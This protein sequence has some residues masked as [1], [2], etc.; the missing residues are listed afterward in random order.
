MNIE[1]IRQSADENT[2]PEILTQL[3]KS[4]DHQTRKYVAKNPNTPVE[5]LFELGCEFPGE[6]LNNPI[7]LLL[8]LE[9]PNFIT[10]IPLKTLRSLAYHSEATLNLITEY[11][12]Q[13]SSAGLSKSELEFLLK[14]I[15][16]NDISEKALK[17]LTKC[18]NEELAE[19]ARLHVNYS[20]KLPNSA[21]IAEN[22]LVKTIKQIDNSLLQEQ[23]EALARIKLIPK[24]FITHWNE[25]PRTARLLYYIQKIYSTQTESEEKKKPIDDLDL[26]K[27]SKTTI[28][29]FQKLA[30]K[31]DH[32]L[33]LALAQS[34]YTPVSILINLIRLKDTEVTKAIANNPITPEAILNKLAKR[35]I[36]S[37]GAEE[38][39]SGIEEMKQNIREQANFNLDNSQVELFARMMQGMKQSMQSGMIRYDGG[40]INS[41]SPKSVTVAPQRTKQRQNIVRDFNTPLHIL[42]ELVKDKSLWLRI[43]RHPNS[44]V[45]ILAKIVQ[46][47]NSELKMECLSNPN[48]PAKI[49]KQFARDKNSTEFVLIK[50]AKHPNTPVEIIEELCQ[51]QNFNIRKAVL[52]NPSTPIKL[53]E[54]LAQS[55][56][57]LPEFA[58]NSRAPVETLAKLLQ[59]TER[60]NSLIWNA[61]AL[62]PATPGYL[63]EYIYNSIEDKQYSRNFSILKAIAKN[64]NT[65]V[66]ILEL[67]ATFKSNIYPIYVAA[68]TENPNL[69]EHLW[70][71]IFHYDYSISRYKYSQIFSGQNLEQFPE[72]LPIFL[73]QYPQGLPLVL[74]HYANSEFLLIRLIVLINLQISLNIL[75]QA[76]KSVYWLERY[77]VVQNPSTTVELL[78]TLANDSNT[79]VRAAARIKLETKQ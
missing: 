63:L 5:I 39:N 78:E 41:R 32:E 6:F 49:L 53:L 4:K 64:P 59:K 24:H 44:S 28:D 48:L 36:Y 66:E 27:D 51:K 72:L 12:V 37:A 17:Q 74:E 40:Y 26:I 21:K 55:E 50:V 7:F 14:I 45:E 69:P 75:A 77:T 2:S 19:A 10:K 70:K 8:I 60:T 76:S 58:N 65:P 13:Q 3:A 15:S 47:G 1:Q 9:D 34:Y 16:Q 79:I 38:F 18:R 43:A 31:G 35:N 54:E 73:T 67:L 30:N 61:I 57:L 33:N 22:L 20:I 52:I 68:L 62:N 25:K 42:E 71:L 29:I 46:D 11:A 23:L 56:D